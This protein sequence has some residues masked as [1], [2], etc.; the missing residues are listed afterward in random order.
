LDDINRILFAVL[1]R[2]MV[3]FNQLM[4]QWGKVPFPQ[5]TH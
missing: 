3:E 4:T 5:S 1:S 2:A